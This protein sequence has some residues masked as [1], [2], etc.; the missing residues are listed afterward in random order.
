MQR[1]PGPTSHSSARPLLRP[2]A[3]QVA[4]VLGSAALPGTPP[5][6]PAQVTATLPTVP[7]ACIIH[8]RTLT[9]CLKDLNHKAT[10]N[11]TIM[12]W[13]CNKN[14]T[15]VQKYLAWEIFKLKIKHV[16]FHLPATLLT[17]TLFFPF[18]LI[19]IY[20]VGQCLILVMY[21]SSLLQHRLGAKH[22]FQ[23]T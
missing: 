16:S 17:E 18:V 8:S 23:Y 4:G 22:P 6:Q 14:K 20:R 2:K 21:I 12:K 5:L 15:H 11:T 3:G 13:S 9:N 10:S 19:Q 7:R 1:P